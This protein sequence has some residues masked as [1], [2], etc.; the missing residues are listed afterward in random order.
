LKDAIISGILVFNAEL[1]KN[2]LVFIV[3]DSIDIGA[4]YSSITKHLDFRKS[5]DRL[6]R[7]R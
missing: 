2:D 5:R 3:D 4:S 1:G 6:F 7:F